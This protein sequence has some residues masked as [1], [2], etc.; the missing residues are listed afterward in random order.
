MGLALLFLALSS[1]AGADFTLTEED[2]FAP[3]PQV[4]SAARLVQP[5]ADAPVAMT[6]IDRDMIE[7][8]SAINIPELLRLVPGFQVT[9][10]E[11]IDAISTYQGYADSLPRRMQ[12]LVDGRSVYNPGI[13]GVIWAALPLTL[14]Q[15]ERIEVVRGPNAAAYGSNAF[16]GTINIVSRSPEASE[17][18]SARMM[19][20]SA[21]TQEGEI[22][23]AGGFDG[24]TYR[25]NASSSDAGGF[26]DKSDDSESRIFNVQGIYRPTLEDSLTFN[27]G[28][29][30]TDFDS[31]AFRVPRQR[32]YDTDYQQLIWNHR[33]SAEQDLRIQLFHNGLRSPDDVSFVESGLPVN[34]DYSLSTERYDFELQHRWSPADH[35]RVSWGGGA[36]RDQAYG[37][38]I[39][40]TNDE[41]ERDILRLF[42]NAEWQVHPDLVLNA[43]LMGEDYSDLGGFF[44]PRI[45][46]NWHAADHHTFRV[47]AARAYRMP[48]FFE[49]H[50]ELKVDI[51]LT[52]GSP[53]LIEILGTESNSPEEIRSFELGY[54]FD[55][56]A[57]SGTFDFR[58]FHHEVTPLLHDALD[59]GIVPDRP[60]RFIEA[61]TLRTT[62]AE[63]QANF[64]PTDAQLVHV[65]Y[66]YSR[67][68]GSRLFRIDANGNPVPAAGGNPRS[69]AETTPEH[70]L[71]AMVAQRLADDWQLSGTYYYVSAMEWLGEGDPVDRQSRIDV[72][73]SKRFRH[74]QGDIELSLKVHNLLDDPY[75]EFA[76]SDPSVGVSGNLA[77][78]RVYAQ[79]KFILR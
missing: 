21:D 2:F 43:G 75:W 54:L 41:L 20:G 39:F 60:L 64:R 32:K 1:P 46:L 56:P 17:K 3:M 24:F 31:E 71:T 72:K 58:L 9:Y 8:S 5:L 53:D 40:D 27:G 15:V 7:A 63:I 18:F 22:A 69:N 37:P 51:L 77:E 19:N 50:G 34:V 67:T 55:A 42:A 66:A 35:W 52:P 6:I 4:L 76:E 16:L 73:L 33:F 38:G 29:R 70:T 30:D 57:I 59:Y 44:S 61:G 47:S 25:I 11:G 48:T 26:P 12:V 79:V 10:T 28:M 36:R 78:R 49:Q 68:G 13:N 14:D 74:E 62:G 65:A 23:H 45:A